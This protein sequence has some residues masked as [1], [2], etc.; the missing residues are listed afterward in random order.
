[1]SSVREAPVAATPSRRGTQASRAVTL[2]LIAAP[3]V[4]LG[5]TIP[6]LWGRAVSPLDLVVAAALYLVSGFGIAVGYHRLFTHSSF[7]A[8]RPLRLALAAAGSLA[9]EGSVVGWVANHR[10]HH[11]HSDRDGDPH[12]PWR[13]GGSPLGRLRGL[14]WA[15]IGWL[16]STDTTDARRFAPDLLKDHDMVAISRLFPVAAV[17]SLAIP[18]AIGWAITGTV[19]GAVTGLVWGGLVRV[20]LLHHMTWS[21]NSLCHMYGRRPFATKDH[22]ANLAAL[23][24]LSFGESWHNF[25]HAAPSSARHGVLPGQLDLAAIVIR[26]LERVGLAREVRWPS[27]ARIARARIVAIPTPDADDGSG[28]AS[29]HARPEKLRPQAI[30]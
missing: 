8:R 18:A 4:A 13:Y 10:R 19:V 30:R 27:P 26:G 12:S 28:Y 3:A 16:F 17:L 9:L 14:A 11:M 21:V 20:A 2:A 1:M 29:S 23:A 25:H 15:H 7:V 5:I 22:S 24:V 6:I